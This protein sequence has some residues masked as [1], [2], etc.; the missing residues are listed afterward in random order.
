MES[1]IQASGKIIV[2]FHSYLFILFII[3]M[4]D[5]PRIRLQIKELISTSWPAILTTVDESGM[6]FTRAMNNLHHKNESNFAQSTFFARQGDWTFFFRTHK[7]S[8][9]VRQM[10]KANVFYG[11]GREM[12]GLTLLGTIRELND[13]KIKETLWR[14]EWENF[15]P[16]GVTDPEYTV[17]KFDAVEFRLFTPIDDEFKR[18]NGP[19]K[20]LK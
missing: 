17:L 12:S 9:K 5:I 13:P 2:F 7:S 8:A 16:Y 15:F 6:P 4:P 20:D 3:T 14:D 19:V 18:I 11:Q 10:G 1:K